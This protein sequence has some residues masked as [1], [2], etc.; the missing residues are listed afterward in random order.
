MIYSSF[1]KV[2]QPKWV[3]KSAHCN[4]GVF[5]SLSFQWTEP[6]NM[7][8]YVQIGKQMHAKKNGAFDERSR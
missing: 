5:V 7:C 8:M 6:G 3:L 4:L 1:R 2:A